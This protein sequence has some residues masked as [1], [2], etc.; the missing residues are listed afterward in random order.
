MGTRRYEGEPPIHTRIV[1]EGPKSK[2]RKV[3]QR[4]VQYSRE[5]GYQV[6]LEEVTIGYLPPFCDD[7]EQMERVENPRPGRPRKR[8]AESPR[9]VE[10]MKKIL[11][12]SDDRDQSRVVYRLE[13]VYFVILMAAGSGMGSCVEVAQFWSAHKSELSKIF[14]DLPDEAISHDL[15]RNFYIILGKIKDNSLLMS[16]NAMLLHEEGI[17]R[18]VEAIDDPQAREVFLKDILAVD[19]QAVRG[20]R[21]H[22]GSKHAKYILNVFNCSKELVLAQVLVGDKTNEIPH[23]REVVN[24]LDITGSI[25]TADALHANPGF[26]QAVLDGGADYCIGLK[27]NQKN[28][29]ESVKMLFNSTK[30]SQMA[31]A[32]EQLNNEHGR[33]EQRT[34]RVLPGSLVDVDVLEKW[35]GLEEG[36]VVEIVSKRLEKANDKKHDDIR[37]FISSLKFNKEYIAKQMLHVV[38]SHWAIENKLHWSLDVIYDQDKTHCKNAEYLKGRTLMNKIVYNITTVAQ[39]VYENENGKKI[40]RKSMRTWFTSAAQTSLLLS[41]VSNIKNVNLIG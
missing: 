16:L 25:V 29:E 33:Q 38:R 40:S 24:Q 36:C 4:K 20:T 26:V 35:P 22:P 15:V 27:T 11:D 9:T 41:K 10:D 14:P 1:K 3:V 32:Y 28:S 8:P 18:E 7:L 23:G 30:W 12:V 21:K 2:R 19:G 13:I 39:K 37:Y 5:K 34:I 6:T 17:L 31:V